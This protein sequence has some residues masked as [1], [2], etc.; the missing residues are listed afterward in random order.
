MQHMNISRLGGES[1]LQ[2]LATA[3]ATVT[4][5]LNLPLQLKATPDHLAH[6]IM[7]PEIVNLHPHGY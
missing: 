2:L 7:R 6:D 3:T 5:T 1:E 4:A